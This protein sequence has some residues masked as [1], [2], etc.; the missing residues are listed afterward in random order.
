[1]SPNKEQLAS[2]NYQITIVSS[3]AELWKCSL[4]GEKSLH[5]TVPL[6]AGEIICSFGAKKILS[7]PNYLTVQWNEREHIMLA[8]DFLQYINHSCTPNVFFDT[9]KSVLRCLRKI[10]VGQELTFFYPSTEW[11]M[12]QGFDCLCGVDECLGRI[13]G[14]AHLHPDILQKYLL[15]AHVY[16]KL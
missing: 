8:P 12:V 16:Q 15:S 4:T 3:F 6:I 7:E 14:A 5:A 1:M 2:L 11:S 10:E 9:T 13:Q